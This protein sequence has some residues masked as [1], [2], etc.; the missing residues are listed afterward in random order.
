MEFDFATTSLGSIQ[1]YHYINKCF[2]AIMESKFALKTGM[3]KSCCSE[4]SPE[5]ILCK[6]VFFNK[7]ASC[8]SL[9]ANQLKI[10]SVACFLEKFFKTAVSL[11][12]SELLK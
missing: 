1:N 11:S 2:L 5:N 10:D 6:C 7:D 9:P 12:T 3:F 4:K 8:Q